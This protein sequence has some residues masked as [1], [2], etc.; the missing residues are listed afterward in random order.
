[1]E[2]I[3]LMPP[4][5]APEFSRASAVIRKENSHFQVDEILG[6]DLAGEGEHLYVH[7][8]KNGQNTAWVKEQLAASLK[9][10]PRDI[11][12]SGLKDR[13]AVTRQWLSIYTPK[14]DLSLDSVNIE[15]VEILETKRHL[16]KLKPGAHESNRFQ[17]LLS[18]FTTDTS[19]IEAILEQVRE[20]GFP[21]YFGSQRFGREGN[22]L[23]EGWRLIA[24]RRLNRHKKKSIYLSSLR[25]FLF[26][27]VLL[28][29]IERQQASESEAEGESF[30]STGPLWGR[31]RLK[32]EVE[33]TQF[34]QQVLAPWAPLC[35]ALEF[36]GLSQERR[37]LFVVP[38]QFDWQWKADDQL[39]LSFNLPPG[40]Y[41]TALLAEIASIID[42][43]H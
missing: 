1:M 11:G 41:A 8:R 4:L 32:L 40:S 19:K 25:S 33:Q 34:E 21:N 30:D 3:N 9:I 12:H 43:N 16:K 22:N 6:V 13:H 18:S 5:H 7:V 37:E 36:S 15:G 20:R 28:T 39:E 35:N 24:N 29:R 42:A 31:G 17:I 23:T 26:N 10:S 38:T 14:A 2:F 27:K